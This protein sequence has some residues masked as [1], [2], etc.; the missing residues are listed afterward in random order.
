MVRFSC[1]SSANHNQRSKKVQKLGGMVRSSFEEKSQGS[2]N[3]KPNTDEYNHSNNSMEQLTSPS[4][5]EDCWRSENLN[6]DFYPEDSEELH[7]RMRM[8]K[9]QSLG[10]ILDKERDFTGGDVTD[11]EIEGRGSFDH[12][13]ENNMM[14]M[15][16]SLNGITSNEL[17]NPGNLEP[18]FYDQHEE[19]D[20]VQPFDMTSDNAHHGSLFSIEALQQFDGEQHADVDE[21]SADHVAKSGFLS[22]DI[23]SAL[24]RSQS[25]NHLRVDTTGSTEDVS[26]DEVMG[27]RSRSFEN[28]NFP[29]E[30]NLD[31]EGAAHHLAS[32]KEQLLSNA[33]GRFSDVHDREEQFWSERFDID[34]KSSDGCD[35]H[36]YDAV[37]NEGKEPETDDVKLKNIQQE[38]PILDC[39][40]LNPRDFRI[41]RIQ[42]WISK[43]DIESDCIVEE[44]GESSSSF[45]D[46]EP[47]VEGD[48]PTTKLDAKSQ[49]GMEM[50]YNYISSLTATS[51][52]AQMANLGLVA[53]PFLN[54]FVG[55]RVLNLS[56]NAIVRITAG[57]L[58]RGLH[59]LNLSKNNIAVIE[60][61]RDLTR[62]CV[63]DLSY[64]RI[65]RIGHGLASCSSLKELYLAGNKISE[66][67]GLHRLLKLNILDLRSNK[68][69][70]AKG[71]GQ[72]AANYGS[73]QV[74]NLDGNPAQRN[75]GDEQLKKYLL[76]LLPN[77]VYYNK[78]SIKA[79]GTKEISD[80]PPRSAAHHFD[81]STRTENK[82]TRRSSQGAGL[83][84][85]PLNPVRSSH[86]AGSMR[87]PKSRNVESRHIH[88]PPVASKLPHHL[89]DVDKK[90]VSLQAS[91]I[92]RIRSE[93]NLS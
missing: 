57:A 63:L 61:L 91:P 72:L 62:L 58:P 60:G 5:H 36:D 38:S 40:E 20:S 78:H 83:H 92:R 67:E 51:S 11:D 2:A 17:Y 19:H 80:R 54:A 14:R 75:V 59:M 45:L 28:L 24:A 88:L 93:G 64:N 85:L 1:F 29:Q 34:G 53:V 70:T 79:I 35:S 26:T 23:P 39:D 73:L 77:L 21:Q 41:Q 49:L 76:S 87:Q 22:S 52:A 33:S 9:S 18:S 7:Q 74:I 13:H 71:L 55:L 43:I 10:C 8:K 56:G 69:S 66:I 42:D 4:S 48:V 65:I 37:G 30:S 81:R 46:K 86:A 50:A 89:P 15:N 3:T 16:G 32:E 84:K 25:V 6:S 82:M 68:L 47:Q 90:L 27:L 31:R 12:S 44:P